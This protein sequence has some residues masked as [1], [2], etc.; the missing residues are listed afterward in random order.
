MD[1]EEQIAEYLR[2]V[3]ASEVLGKSERRL[4]LL[5]YLIRAELGGVGESLKAYA[6]GIDALNKPD[7]YDPSIDSSVRVEMG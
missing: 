5:E 4:H 7:D 1:C 6:I 2:C 3:A